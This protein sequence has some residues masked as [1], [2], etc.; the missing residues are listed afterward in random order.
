[1]NRFLFLFSHLCIII[2]ELYPLFRMLLFSVSH[3][4]PLSCVVLQML[5][6]EI[7]HPNNKIMQ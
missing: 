4:N 3:Q 1:M 2:E 5:P 6:I 7:S